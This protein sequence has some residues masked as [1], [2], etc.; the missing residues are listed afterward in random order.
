MADFKVF[1]GGNLNAQPLDSFMKSDYIGGY[2]VKYAA[3]LTNR[4]KVMPF[5]IDFGH[6]KWRDFIGD[7]AGGELKG[8]DA[9]GTHLL[10]AG[11]ELS[12]VAIEIRQGADGSDFSG[13]KVGLK[14]VTADGTEEETETTDADQAKFFWPVELDQLRLH[15]PGILYVVFEGVDEEDVS[16]SGICLSVTPGLIGYASEY[17]CYCGSAPCDTEYPD[18][19]CSPFATNRTA[20]GYDKAGDAFSKAGDDDG[21]DDGDGGGDP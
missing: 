12:G 14:L 20:P 17:S 16:K 19:E 7:E 11:T 1:D 4:H 2:P 3:H 6:P 5:H 15:Q 8:T 21:D 10:A 9:L 18:P 13:M